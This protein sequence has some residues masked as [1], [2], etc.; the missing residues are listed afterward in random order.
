MDVNSLHQQ[1]FNNSEFSVYSVI[2]GASLPELLAK[3]EEYEPEHTCLFRG[4]LPFDVAEAAPHLV[5]LEADS[6][7]TKWLL[8]RSLA[9][10]CCIYAHSTQDFLVMRQHFRSLLDAEM[11]DGEIVH[12][13]YYDPRVLPVYLPTCAEE[14]EEVMYREFV[15]KYLVMNSGNNKLELFS[16]KKS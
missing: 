10:P 13:R 6:A 3:L 16:P 1:L 5:K 15:R 4:E 8:E 11:P 12:F 2:D 9:L 14:E 7:F